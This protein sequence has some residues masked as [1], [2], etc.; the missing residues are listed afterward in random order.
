MDKQRQSHEQAL[1]MRLMLAQQR[2]HERKTGGAKPNSVL[3]PP[4][5]FSN[6]L[7]DNQN[8]AGDTRVSPYL[9]DSKFFN[10][11]PYYSVKKGSGFLDGFKQG[12]RFT[13]M[14]SR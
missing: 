12:F 10:Q 13:D 8:Y 1:P 6:Y 7:R 2:A 4:L 14:Y 11:R 5:G 9:P 3:T